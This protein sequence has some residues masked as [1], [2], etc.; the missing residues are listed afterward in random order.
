MAENNNPALEPIEKSAQAASM[1]RGAVKTGK[2][3]AGAAQGAAAGGP[4]GAAVGFVWSNR[5]VIGKVIIA[6]IALLMIPI[7]FLCMLP[8]L[9]FGGFGSSH[10]SYDPDTP[11][12]NSDTAITESAN[13]ICQR[14]DG[15]LSEALANTVT[16]I[17]QDFS[18]SGAAQID[19][20][21]PYAAQ[22][23]YDA[24]K[25]VSMYCAVNEGNVSAIT[26]DGLEQLLRGHMAEFFSYTCREETRAVMTTDPETGAQVPAVEVDPETGDETPVTEVWRIYTVAYK[27]DSYF[28][29]QIFSLTDEQKELADDYASNLNLFLQDSRFQSSINSAFQKSTVINISGYTDPDTKNNLDLVQWA[30]EAERCRWGYVWGTYGCVLD[31]ALYEYKLKQ[32]PDGVGKYADFITA[33]WLGGRTADCVGL[34]K[35]YSWLDVDTLTVGYATNGMPDIGADSM[36]YNA[37]EKGT[38]GTIP[39]IPGLAVWHAGHIGIYIGNGE[40]IE[41]MGTKYGVVRT[42]L[43]GSRWT[44]WLKI[45]YISYS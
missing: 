29:T 26:A 28:S 6:V 2:A 19:I 37:T 10:S 21:N 30:I 23:S 32:Y 13:E 45:P 3:I 25:L 15:V 27:G 8:A 39:E 11:I 35:G 31:S 24:A 9:I 36:Y 5:K 14:A 1:I 20:I 16:A 38:I 18:R 33:N 42:Q 40:V 44:H 7:M 22:I 12:L 17:Q 34:I 41:A 43:E 4:A